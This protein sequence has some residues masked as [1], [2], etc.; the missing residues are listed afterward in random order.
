MNECQLCGYP[1]VVRFVVYTP[2]PRCH[3]LCSKCAWVQLGAAPAVMWL[4]ME[5]KAAGA[6]VVAEAEAI[7]TEAV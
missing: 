6:D 4:A 7:L 1:A 5:S 2:Y 3:V